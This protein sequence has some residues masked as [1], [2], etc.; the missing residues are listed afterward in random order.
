MQTTSAGA[1]S[2]ESKGGPFQLMDFKNNPPSPSP[3]KNIKIDHN[4]LKITGREAK[5]FT[6]APVESNE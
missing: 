5:G 1:G 3:N 4:I 6:A 2:S